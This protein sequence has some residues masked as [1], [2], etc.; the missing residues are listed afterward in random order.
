MIYIGNELVKFAFK[1][2]QKIKYIYQGDTLIY[3]NEYTICFRYTPTKAILTWLHEGDGS[4]VEDVNQPEG[5]VQISGLHYNDILHWALDCPGYHSTG[6]SYRVVETRDI[7]VALPAMDCLIMANVYSE[8]VPNGLITPL[9]TAIFIYDADGS[10]IDAVMNSNTLTVT[11]PYDSQYRIKVTA[12]G[13]EGYESSLFTVAGATTHDILMEKSKYTFTMKTTPTDAKVTA[14]NQQGEEVPVVQ[15]TAGANQI[16]VDYGTVV[17]YS[18]SRSGYVTL[19]GNWTATKDE[20]LSIS[21]ERQSYT[22]TVTV[23]DQTKYTEGVLKINGTTVSVASNKYTGTFKYEDRVDIEYTA[24]GVET[25]SVQVTIPASNISVVLEELVTYKTYDV[26]IDRDPSGLT[27]KYT[28]NGGSEITNTNNSIDNLRYNDV[29][30]WSASATGYVSKTN[31][32]LVITGNTRLD[33]ILTPIDY[34]IAINVY[35]VSTNNGLITASGTTISILDEDDKVI[36]AVIN[37]NT[38]TASIPYDTLYK[39][40]VSA[41]GHEGYESSLMTVTGDDTVNVI[42]NKT[43]YTLTINPTPSDATVTFS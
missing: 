42:L 9:N 32:S 26:G 7:N 25:Y 39:V 2:E 22:L 14:T 20:E 8:A 33:V 3:P 30:V 43:K 5:Y 1:G 10:L 40:L 37:S 11:L 18:V 15:T 31:Q 16:T 13:H 23:P 41:T 34:S 4:P 29:I 38:L 35:S 24:N 19:A 36:N 12:L 21:L 17:N 27:F 6:G 28:L